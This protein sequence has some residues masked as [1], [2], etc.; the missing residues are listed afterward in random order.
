MK[1]VAVAE[2]EKTRNKKKDPELDRATI[3]VSLPDEILY[4]IVRLQMNSAACKNKGFI[5]DGYPRTMQDAKNIFLEK[6]PEEHHEATEGTD[7]PFPGYSI[8]QDI[9]PQFMIILNAEDGSLKQRV[10]DLP[11]DKTANTHYTEAHMDRRLKIYRES[12]TAESGNSV[13]EFF[14]KSLAK[15]NGE[16]PISENVKTVAAIGGNG[17][18]EHLVD[19][20]DFIERRGKPCCLNLITDRDNKFLKNLE[21]QN[22]PKAA[23]DKP[24][25]EDSQQHETVEGGTTSL[26]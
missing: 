12:C 25:A 14:M 23:G 9:L 1:D 18:I 13:Q 16:I 24:H 2:Y 15:I 5:L 10:K 22:N 20:Q 3:K 4:K 17:D 7:D 26:T 11:V 8:I 21:K 19:I 6:L